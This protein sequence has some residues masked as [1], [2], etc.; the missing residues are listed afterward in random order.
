MDKKI[1]TSDTGRRITRRDFI[2]TLAVGGTAIAGGSIFNRIV[3]I[4]ETETST[5]ISAI[6][7]YD[8]DIRGDILRGL[9]ELG[10][11]STLISGKNVLLKPNLVEPSLHAPHINTHPNVIRAAVDAFRALGAAY[12][13]VAEGAGHRRDGLIVLEE[14][15]L[16]DVLYKE[17]IPFVD[18]N[19]SDVGKVPN[20]G[21]ESKLRELFLPREIIE[22]DVIVSMAKMKTHHWVGA[23]LTMKNLFGIMPGCVY[24]WPKNVLHWAGIHETIYDINAT[25][26]PHFA[27]IDGIVGMEGDGPIMGEPVNS[28][29]IIMGRNPAAVDATSARIMGINPQKIGYLRMASGNIGTI[30][31]S[32]I[33]QVG[34]PIKYV[35]KIFKLDQNIPAH[36]NLR[37]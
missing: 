22:A 15:G 35:S 24:G 5:F 6:S 26:R 32:L 20:R 4:K 23:T 36:K 13:V 30:G 29:V 21:C 28:N 33:H 17:K 8:K 27:I 12:V 1:K 16:A 2:K 19:N 18:L 3:K 31:E 11:T 14:S 37:L 10:V 25:V 9:S 7:S 34:E